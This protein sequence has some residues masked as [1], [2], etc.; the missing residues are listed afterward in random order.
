[1]ST[2]RK[3]AFHAVKLQ[4]F[5]NRITCDYAKLIQ[6]KIQPQIELFNENLIKFIKKNQILLFN[7]EKNIFL[8]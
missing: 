5:T 6:L 1:M 4:M 2:M 8:V 7:N 3:I